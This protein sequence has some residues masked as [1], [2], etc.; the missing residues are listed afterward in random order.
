M[1][2][3]RITTFLMANLT[4]NSRNPDNPADPVVPLSCSLCGAAN[5]AG[6]DIVTKSSSNTEV[7]YSMETRKNCA[8]AASENH[9]PQ[10]GSNVLDEIEEP[11][12][13]E[14]PQRFVLFP[15]HYHDIWQV[16]SS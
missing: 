8:V 14:N 10:N 3:P 6:S 15:I 4:L 13:T 16:P 12:L 11:L 5:Q 2:Q 9:S 1:S 7:N